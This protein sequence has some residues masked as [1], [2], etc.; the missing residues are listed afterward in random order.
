MS[1]VRALEPEEVPEEYRDRVHFDRQRL[2]LA[3]SGKYKYLEI[4]VNCEKCGI[5]R[6][7]AVN[8]IRSWCKGQRRG[9]FPGTHRECRF[10]KRTVD[11]E[12]YVRVYV[13]YDF[14]RERS[15]YEPEHRAVMSEV[16]GR[17]L[18]KYETVHHINGDRQ[19]NRPENLQL[20]TGRHGKGV[21]HECGDCGSK[22]IVA[23]Q[24]D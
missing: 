21:V 2:A 3:V 17:P 24:L 1:K 15:L 16:L 13:G 7:V 11:A 8:A 5:P 9:P 19:D 22:N 23:V 4:F 20:R 14:D 6:E 12:G 18:T 10:T